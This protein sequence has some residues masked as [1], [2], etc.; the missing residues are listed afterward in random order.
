MASN[1]ALQNAEYVAPKR[2]PKDEAMTDKLTAQL[3]KMIRLAKKKSAQLDVIT[4]LTTVPFELRSFAICGIEGTNVPETN[5]EKRP[6]M[7]CKSQLC[8]GNVRGRSPVTETMARIT[9]F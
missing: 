2:E 8:R 5:T 9:R 3:E 4:H 1:S 7:V 6:F